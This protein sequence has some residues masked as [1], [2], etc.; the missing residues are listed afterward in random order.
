MA[1]GW[2]GGFVLFDGVQPPKGSDPVM[3]NVFRIICAIILL[4][5][6]GCE[7]EHPYD[8]QGGYNNGYYQGYGYGQNYYHG[9][10]QYYHG[11]PGYPQYRAY[12]AY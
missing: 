8:H 11:Y 1:A 6:V 12:P 4:G 7:S 10:P 5:A 2:N 9:Y 3:K